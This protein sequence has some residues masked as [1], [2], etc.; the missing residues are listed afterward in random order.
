MSKVTVLGNVP[1]GLGP[2][3]V[4]GDLDSTA[5]RDILLP[6]LTREPEGIK[7][8]EDG[9]N[10]PATRTEVPAPTLQVEVGDTVIVGTAYFGHGYEHPGMVTRVLDQDTIKVTVFPD[11]ADP[12]PIGVCH[13]QK[14]FVAPGAVRPRLEQGQWRAR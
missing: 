2:D 6:V 14:V 8:F 3:V 12:F 13:R 1:G 11:D 7:H 4:R 5:T 10:P 9:D